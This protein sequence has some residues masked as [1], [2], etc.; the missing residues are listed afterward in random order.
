MSADLPKAHLREG[1][2]LFSICDGRVFFNS[3]YSALVP[4]P[5]KS[6]PGIAFTSPERNSSKRR[7]ATDAHFLSISDSGGK[8]KSF[9]VY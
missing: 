4:G 7:L 2:L 1:D 3:L 5:K 8:N 9:Y 6:S